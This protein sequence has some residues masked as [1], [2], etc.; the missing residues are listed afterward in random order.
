MREIIF[1]VTEAPEEGWDARVRGHSAFA[2]GG[3]REG[4]KEMVRDA[5]LCDIYDPAPAP[6]VVRLYFVGEEAVAVRDC[7][8]ISRCGRRQ[9]A[10]LPLRLERHPDEGM[11]DDRLADHRRRPARRDRAGAPRNC[12]L[13]WMGIGHSE[14]AI[15]LSEP[16][17]AI[18][19][20]RSSD[21][22]DRA[23]KHRTSGE[24]MTCNRVETIP[25]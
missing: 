13:R 24:A 18:V 14:M 25:V 20:I 6:R 7:G 15:G 19:G 1:E 23:P 11:P 5:V 12:G 16:P 4:L 8:E 21:S 9:A 10:R 22:S 2:Q 3:D 17:I